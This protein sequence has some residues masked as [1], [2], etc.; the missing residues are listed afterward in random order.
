MY[1]LRKGDCRLLEKGTPVFSQLNAELDD[2]LVKLKACV[3][4]LRKHVPT[5]ARENL[6]AMNIGY[7]D[8]FIKRHARNLPPAAAAGFQPLF[9]A[10]EAKFDEFDA[11]LVKHQSARDQHMANKLRSSRYSSGLNYAIV[12]ATHLHGIREHLRDLPCVFM[13]PKALLATSHFTSLQES[14]RDEL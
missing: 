5:A 9:L 4:Y 8:S 2:L 7:Y 10:S 14:S 11:N 13:L 6:L 1:N 12:G 3:D